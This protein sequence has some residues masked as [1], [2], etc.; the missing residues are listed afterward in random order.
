MPNFKHIFAVAKIEAKLLSRSTTFKILFAVFFL[1]TL[2]WVVV[3]HLGDD[4]ILLV[5]G[6]LALKCFFFFS[7][8]RMLL[9]SFLAPVFIRDDRNM[10]SYKAVSTRPFTNTSYI[11]GKLLGYTGV[12]LVMDYFFMVILLVSSLI[13]PNMANSLWPYLLYPI[14]ITLPLCVFLF[15]VNVFA[16]QIFYPLVYFIPLVMVMFFLPLADLK[17]TRYLDLAGIT[18]PLAYS[19]ITGFYKIGFVI[20]QRLIYVFSGL[21]FVWASCLLSNFTRRPGARKKYTN[22][23]AIIVVCLLFAAVFVR[24]DIIE[25]LNGDGA[26][27]GPIYLSKDY[28]PLTINSCDLTVIHEGTSI[29]VKARL[30]ITNPNDSALERLQLKHHRIFKTYNVVSKNRIK[31]YGNDVESIVIDLNTPLEP[32]ESMELEISDYG[33]ILPTAS[34]FHIPENIHQ[35][36]HRAGLTTLGKQTAFLEDDYVLLP[37]EMNWYPTSHSGYAVTEPGYVQRGLTEFS[38]EVK[39]HDGLTVISQGEMT[40]LGDNTYRFEPET[41]LTQMSLTIGRYQ[42]ASIE[43]DDV[44]YSYYWVTNDPLGDTEITSKDLEQSIRQIK[45]EIE[46]TIHLKYPFKRY[47][48]VETPIHFF[49]YNSAF[50]LSGP[51]DQPEIRFIP[52]SSIDLD[53]LTVGGRKRDGVFTL[54]EW[55]FPKLYRTTTNSR[56]IR[57]K[58]TLPSSIFSFGGLWQFITEPYADYSHILTQ[59]AVFSRGPISND[60]YFNLM[61]VNWLRSKFYFSLDWGGGLMDYYYSSLDNAESQ[62]FTSKS[63]KDILAD[64]QYYGEWL[65]ILSFASSSYINLLA[66][67]SNIDISTF[68]NTLFQGFSTDSIDVA[69]GLTE[70]CGT[71]VA[72]LLEDFSEQKEKAHYN[73]TDIQ[74]S[75][76]LIDGRYLNNARFKINNPTPFHGLV[77][78]TLVAESIEL[79]TKV[80]YLEPISEKEIGLVVTDTIRNLHYEWLPFGDKDQR[81]YNAPNEYNSPVNFQLS[82][83]DDVPFFDGIR[84]VRRGT[85]PVSVVMDNLDDGCRIVTT[86]EKKFIQ[87]FA[88][89]YKKKATYVRMKNFKGLEGAP[90]EWTLAK[91]RSERQGFIEFY[92]NYTSCYYTKPGD[93][94]SVVE[95]ATTIPEPGS[96]QVY[97]SVPFGNSLSM[98]ITGMFESGDLGETNVRIFAEDGMHEDTIDISK[99]DRE[100]ALVGTYSFA[101]TTAVIHITDKT[102]AKIVIADAIKLQKAE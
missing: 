13:L 18:L 79:D 64:E 91:T 45:E 41:P 59:Y 53:L 37:A 98:Y 8:I 47:Q 28:I 58:L 99:G 68:E 20:S 60:D 12:M 21:A 15:G 51:Y 54:T 73:L 90:A 92:G 36:V 61:A 17:T 43:V 34:Y 19:A 9:S 44:E 74:T 62:Y 22:K 29:D 39:T 26:R 40:D 94:E 25:G 3:S 42:K 89:K 70:M 4:L 30:K 57:S 31:S 63:L 23:F 88:E 48:I 46:N 10:D 83:T 78:C 6:A 1:I 100:W 75:K 38:L 97:L 2:F 14:I 101:D 102:N 55:I 69:A 7:L 76:H 33:S 67:K 16:A 96:Y 49:G 80:V 66:A 86:K 24:I 35:R 50:G 11:F 82:E 84:D 52:E 5:P 65:D 81:N 27:R 95:Y 71:D 32:N 93:G 56:A 87:R 85:V 77:E 72:A